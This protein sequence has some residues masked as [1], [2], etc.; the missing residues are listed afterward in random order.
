MSGRAERI[1]LNPSEV[2]AAGFPEI[3]LHDGPILVAEEGPDWGEQEVKQFV[4]EGLFGSRPIDAEWP[5][6]IV[7]IPLTLGLSGNYDAAR[8]ALQAAVAQINLEG[9]W[10]KREMLGGDYGEAGKK[11][12]C[13]VTKATLK[14]GHGTKQ[15][16][17]GLDPEAELVLECLPDFYGDVVEGE[18]HEFT[19]DG[20][21]IENVGGDMPARVEEMLVEDKSGNPQA[22]LMFHYRCR[23]LSSANTA[24]WAYNAEALGLLDIAEKVTSPG[25]VVYGTKVVK[26]PKLSTGWTPV[27]STNKA[28]TTF[29]T[30]TGL[31]TV[32]ARVYATSESLPWLRL[33][34]GVG[35]IVA[36]QE[37][38]QV[39]VP[40]KEGWYWVPLGQVNIR[41][42]PFG[43]QRWEGVI[44]ARTEGVGASEAIYIDRIR[45]K[46][47]DECSGV[48]A[49]LQSTTALASVVGS[50]NLI[51][52]SAEGKSET[53]SATEANRGGKWEELGNEG[54][55]KR[56]PGV[57]PAEE[58]E[59]AF[60]AAASDTK[61]RTAL[62]ASSTVG[63]V[64]VRCDIGRSAFLEGL[65]QGVYLR[66]FSSTF[67]VRVVVWS[68]AIGGRLEVPTLYLEY[69]EGGTESSPSPKQVGLAQLGS[70]PSQIEAELNA[71][72]EVVAR[73]A[74]QVY[75]ATLP[76]TFKHGETHAEGKVGIYD[77]FPWAAPAP[78]RTYKNFVA[79]PPP[80]ADAVMYA[81]KPAFLSTGGMFRESEDGNGAGAIGY[82]G[83]DL[84]RL[85]V[86]EVEVAVAPSRGQFGE[87]PDAAKD[88]F[89]VQI[90]HRPC[91]GDVPDS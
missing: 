36:P 46:C 79:S 22:G 62:L 16:V 24:E 69:K 40:G 90:S 6:R 64:N 3:N 48:L 54:A 49:A 86:G 44:Q 2:A 28:G 4:S 52:R 88:K 15:V 11:L 45:L 65:A 59:G 70:I 34:Y 87:L 56:G 7:T 1:I 13:D 68:K 43:A 9:G 27:L 58:P 25:G 42:L 39:Q 20:A 14:F 57:K 89:K 71:A 41:A 26:H 12:F 83:A 72:G 47:D 81:N 29:L 78:V 23:N 30:H 63:A 17:K 31:Y 76:A 21:F 85:P 73:I 32:W 50:D 37:N 53:L 75:R 8:L 82:P 84:P 38:T 19:G 10:L 74:G 60:R 66:Y 80:P 55:F 61:G 77:E 35:D 51:T 33:V 91:F 18:A 5:N 67:W